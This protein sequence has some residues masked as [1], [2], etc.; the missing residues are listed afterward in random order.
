MP[1]GKTCPVC[2]GL[3]ILPADMAGAISKFAGEV[4]A[5][6]AATTARPERLPRY[7]T[8][9]NARTWYRD[10]IRVVLRHYRRIAGACWTCGAEAHHVGTGIRLS[11]G[12]PLGGPVSYCDQHRPARGTVP[13][14]LAAEQ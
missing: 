12:R 5:P 11:D 4:V 9:S 10:G 8:S 1:T 14:E 13:P 6:T 7:K 2:R 3:G